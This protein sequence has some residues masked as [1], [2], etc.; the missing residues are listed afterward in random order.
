MQLINTTIKA[1]LYELK[2]KRLLTALTQHRWT[3][4][5]PVSSYLLKKY[6]PEAIKQAMPADVFEKMNTAMERTASGIG[7]QLMEQK[8]MTKVTKN[9][10]N[11]GNVFSRGGFNR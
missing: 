5:G 4:A 1:H 2:S 8:N 7:S 3:L 11:M 6:G 10:G 9:L